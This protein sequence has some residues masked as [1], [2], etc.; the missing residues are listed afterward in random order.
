V[1]RGD[2]IQDAADAI[3]YPPKVFF[4]ADARGLRQPVHD[5]TRQTPEFIAKLPPPQTWYE[6]SPAIANMVIAGPSKVV[7]RF[8]I[9]WSSASARRFSRFSSARWRPMRSRAF[10]CRWPTICCSSSCRRA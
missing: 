9:R 5:P 8:S 6:R 2:R 1:D 4:R 7:P 10:A 3:A